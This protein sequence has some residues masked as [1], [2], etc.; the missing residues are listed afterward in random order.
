MSPGIREPPF[1]SPAFLFFF[2]L[3]IAFHHMLLRLP[4][5][6]VSFPLNTSQFNVHYVLAAHNSMSWLYWISTVLSP[7][8]TGSNVHGQS[9]AA[10]KQAVLSIRSISVL[11]I[12]VSMVAAIRA[13]LSVPPLLPCRRSCLPLGGLFGIPRPCGPCPSHC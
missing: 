2:H 9:F 11:L 1:L 8:S 6:N 5:Q 12:F 3:L 4:T 10:G 7:H 13:Y